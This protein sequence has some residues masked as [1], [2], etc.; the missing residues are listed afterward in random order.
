MGLRL[1]LAATKRSKTGHMST[2][3]RQFE[4]VVVRAGPNPNQVTPHV[5]RH[6]AITRLVQ[7][8]VDIPTIQKISGHKA[9][10]MVLRYTHVDGSHIDAAIDVWSLAVPGKAPDT[11]TPKLH[12]DWI[13]MTSAMSIKARCNRDKS[14]G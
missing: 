12:T 13:S 8:G 4:R 3:T 5:M 14:N 10:A 11:V 6:T 9:L 7:V 1:F 2:M